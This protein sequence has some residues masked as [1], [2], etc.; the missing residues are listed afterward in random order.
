[1]SEARGY[2]FGN[3]HFTRA[4]AEYVWLQAHRP[5]LRTMPAERLV[6]FRCP[7]KSGHLLGVIYKS[8]SGPLFASIA[9]DLDTLDPVRMKGKAAW[10]PSPRLPLVDEPFTD[11]PCPLNCR[12]GSWPPLT[13][14][15]L[16]WALSL[17]PAR[18]NRPTIIVTTR[19][20]L[21]TPSDTLSLQS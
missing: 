9:P 3:K 20:A 10:D 18:R 21:I 2:P 6:E 1:M 16:K 4:Q 15:A 14:E 13:R 5:R 12:C 11:D 8:R 19:H 17:P 7:P